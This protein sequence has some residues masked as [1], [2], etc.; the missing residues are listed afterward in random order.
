LFWDDANNRLGVG[1]NA[2]LSSLHIE[3]DTAGDP[4]LFYKYSNN[5]VVAGGFFSSKLRGTKGSPSAV[6]S[7][8]RLLSILGRGYRTTGG[9]NFN[10]YSAGITFTASENYT[11]T[12]NGS[13][14]T[15]ETT[16]DLTSL[17]TEKVRILG[18]GYV[19]IGTTT[20]SSKLTVIDETVAEIQSTVCNNTPANAG[21][22][23]VRKSRGSIAS[24][25]A[26]LAGDRLGAFIFSGNNTGSGFHNPCALIGFAAEN[27]TGSAAGGYFAFETTANGTTSRTERMRLLGNGNLL[28]N[29]TTDAGFR[30]DVNGSVRATGSISAAAGVGRGTLLN[31]TL[32]AT[33][34]GDTLVGLDIAPNFTNGAF[35]GLRNW[36]LRLPNGSQI[37]C[38]FSPSYSFYLAQVETTI[39]SPSG[40]VGVQVAAFNVARFFATTGNLT[41]QSGGTFTDIASAR[42]AVNST[43]QGFLPPRMT[44]TQKNAIAS[45]ATGL[46]VYDTTLN[47]IS[48]Y[49]GT[50]WI[51][52]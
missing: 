9:A 41:L 25:S 10:T 32:V 11:S 19:G 29:T 46:M 1:T 14:I 39:N 40:Y 22:F 33:A 36:A 24:P 49:N 17:R 34:N 43:T 3:D 5:P 48:V 20:P 7:G 45:P 51:S 8:D 26:L 50:M 18:N 35:T 28:I 31:Q 44:T 47:L 2:P 15:L 37:G 30:L 12:A 38:G 52:L 27:F 16:Q 13:Y 4:F 42:L 6:L 21:S 23:L